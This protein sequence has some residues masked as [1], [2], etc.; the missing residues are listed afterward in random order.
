MAPGGALLLAIGG[1][2]D[3]MAEAGRPAGA[4]VAG[5]F[6]STEDGL[7]A[8]AEACRLRLP[9]AYWMLLQEAP[10]TRLLA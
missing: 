7:H 4:A 10:A 8:A 6:L 9:S 3:R 2:V 5:G 1:S